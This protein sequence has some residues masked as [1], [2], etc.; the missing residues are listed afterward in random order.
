MRDISKTAPASS[1]SGLPPSRYQVVLVLILSFNLG[2]LFL[3]RNA[4][5]F[6]M[7]LIQPD[8]GLSNTQVGMLSSSLSLT[9]A[10][11]GF[12][13]GGYSDRYEIRKPILIIGTLG[14]CLSAILSGLV[15]SLIFLL[16][17]RLMMGAAQG[18]MLPISQSVVAA[19]VKPER[20]GF[21]MGITQNFGSELL[22]SMLGPIILV[23]LAVAVGWRYGLFAAAIPALICATL[24]FLFVKEPARSSKTEVFKTDVQFRALISN[25]NVFICIILSILL[26]SNYV[27]TFTFLPLFLTEFRG[28][29]P[30]TMALLMSSL[31]VSA[32]FSAFA[33][34]ALSDA[35]GRRPI[36]IGTCLLGVAMPLGVLFYSG[37]LWGLV[38]IFIPGWCLT[39]IFPLFMA[40]VPAESV[41]LRLTATVAGIVVGVGEVIGGVLS[42]LIAGAAADAW[43]L[44]API[45]CI[46]LCVVLSCI[47]SL[48]L[49]ETAPNI[50]EKRSV[51]TYK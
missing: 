43:G 18:G 12:L 9:W 27:I 7:P 45:W 32:L 24:I 19:N 30:S 38:A 34:P 33:V 26:V 29:S 37:P 25:R 23:P 17:A 42:P 21:A 8:L 4:L 1:V 6:L 13:V 22:A 15:G 28:Y 48:A 5:G 46:L 41:D 44:S 49:E 11:A 16:L 51:R 14:F 36:F 39:G 31:G 3:N 40:T 50:I 35:I 20:R 47:V 10:I 2:V